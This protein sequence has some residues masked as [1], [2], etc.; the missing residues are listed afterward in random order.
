VQFCEQRAEPQLRAD[1]GSKWLSAS[2][3]SR[4]SEQGGSLGEACGQL[5]DGDGVLM[6]RRP[7]VGLGEESCGLLARG[8]AERGLAGNG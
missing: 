5:G 6:T 1:L 2:S 4:A 8:W 3:S 7:R